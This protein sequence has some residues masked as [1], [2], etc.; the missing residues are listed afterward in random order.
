MIFMWI[1]MRMTWNLP[2][3]VQ[4][5]VLCHDSPDLGVHVRLKQDKKLKSKENID[6]EIGKHR[7]HFRIISM[8][9]E[10]TP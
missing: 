1:F 8:N 10:P 9:T 5:H 2:L 6:E 7:R 4:W 3:A